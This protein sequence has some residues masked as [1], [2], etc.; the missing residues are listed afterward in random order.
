MIAKWSLGDYCDITFLKNQ[1]N[2]V[3]LE[4]KSNIMITILSPDEFIFFLSTSFLD[5]L[6]DFRILEPACGMQLLR[7]EEIENTVT[8]K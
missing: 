8:S 7:N 3:M 2:F 6:N 5:K 4:V 1:F